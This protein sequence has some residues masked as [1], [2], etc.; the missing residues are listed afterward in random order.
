MDDDFDTLLEE[1]LADPDGADY[2]ALRNS[3][4]STYLYLPYGRDQRGLEDL[5]RLIEAEEWDDAREIVEVLLATDPLSISLRFAYAHVLEAIGE[6]WEATSQ[7]TFADGLLR[8]ILRSGDGRTPETAFHVLDLRETY[9]VV[10]TLGYRVNRTQLAQVGGEWID[11][12]EARG[13][14]G[15]RELY[16]NVTLPQSWLVQVEQTD[17]GEE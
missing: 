5:H 3:Y 10:H 14:E 1:A 12:V 9:L 13:P 8:A 6:D 2:P 7:R 17:T 16:F 11:L 15:D 4:A